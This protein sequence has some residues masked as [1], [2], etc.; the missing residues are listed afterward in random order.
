[1]MARSGQASPQNK[2]SKPLPSFTSESPDLQLLSLLASGL[3]RASSEMKP[4]FLRGRMLGS[5]EESVCERFR[6]RLEIRGRER[7]REKNDS[8]FVW[9]VREKVKVQDLCGCQSA[10]REGLS[11]KIKMTVSALIF[12][13]FLL[14]ADKPGLLM[15][16]YE[17][18]E[19]AELAKNL[20]NLP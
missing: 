2:Q 20:G 14:P 6:E 11:E 4:F 15:R 13:Q 7:P 12:C 5:F 1:M 19:A 10:E 8:V 3:I 16:Y 18:Q 9:V 17:Q